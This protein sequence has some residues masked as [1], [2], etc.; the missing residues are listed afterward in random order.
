MVAGERSA[1]T[2]KTATLKPSDVVRLAHHHENGIEGTTLITQ[3][4][5]IK[6][7]HM[8]ITIQGWDLGQDTQ[9]N[10]ITKALEIF[11]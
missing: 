10:H 6:F 7:L 11:G 5:P 8:G 2:G 4:P 3:S 9:P 1:S